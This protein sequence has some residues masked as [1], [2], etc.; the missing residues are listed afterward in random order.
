MPDELSAALFAQYMRISRL[1]AGQ[2]DFQSAIDAVAREIMEI[3]PHDHMDV[4]IITPGSTFHTAYESGIET[5]WSKRPPASIDQSPLRHLLRGE[6]DRILTADACNDPQ[7]HYEGSFSLPILEHRL[8]GRVHAALKVHGET[9]GVISCSSL[10]AGSYDERH[11]ERA[12]AIAD[13]LAPYFY[14]LLT[15]EQARHSAIIEAETR[16]RE[17]ALRQ[18]ARRLT[19]ALDAERQRI[20][21]ELHDQTLADMTRFSRRLER[22]SRMDTLPGETLEPLCRSLQQSMQDL[23]QI[24][25]QALP[26]VLQLFGVA[27]AIENHLERSARDSGTETEWRIS[28]ETEGASA[29]LPQP[30]SVA[31]Y[32]IAQEA[33]NN[34]FRHSRASRLDVRLW[35]DKGQMVMEIRD[36]GIG[37]SRTSSHSGNGIENMRTRARLIS[38]QFSCGTDAGGTFV[39]VRLT[40]PVSGAIR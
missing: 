19:E 32:R 6:I 1:L 7:F 38:A 8:R 34:A 27:E 23:R 10:R 13:L 5:E 4:C 24:I 33:I 28:D 2:L 17:E 22:L 26:S 18:G 9:I 16:V 15:A 39:I 31:F 35:H 29:R 30:V 21:M 11:L 20:G 14:A 25:E 40:V 3:V 12:S 36:D 37:M